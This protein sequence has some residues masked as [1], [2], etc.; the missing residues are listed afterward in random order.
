[1]QILFFK[2][3]VLSWKPSVVVCPYNSAVKRLKQENYHSLRPSG[4]HGKYQAIL[5]YD[6]YRSV[7]FSLA[8]HGRGGE[9]RE[10][11]RERENREK[12]CL[13]VFMS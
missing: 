7:R 4:E 6:S 2:M 13:G 1:M 5:S 9:G 8:K 10:K 3:E 11:E 12:C